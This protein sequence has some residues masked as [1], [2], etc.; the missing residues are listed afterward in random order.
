VDYALSGES[1]YLARLNEF[2]DP[3]CLSAEDFACAMLFDGRTTAAEAADA[4]AGIAPDGEASEQT[5]RVGSLLERAGLIW[6]ERGV[7]GL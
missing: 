5:I 2:D 6:Q 7:A 1:V 3:L 4:L